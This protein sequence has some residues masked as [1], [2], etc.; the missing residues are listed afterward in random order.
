MPVLAIAISGI[1]VLCGL[2]LQELAVSPSVLGGV[3]IASA[4]LGYSLS[5]WQVSYAMVLGGTCLLVA[6]LLWLDPVSRLWVNGAWWMWVWG[7]VGFVLKETPPKRS[8][9]FPHGGIGIRGEAIASYGLCASGL[10][11]L[12]GLEGAD[13]A[14]TVRLILAI[15]LFVGGIVS[16]S[17]WYCWKHDPEKK[18]SLHLEGIW[19]MEADYEIDLKGFS[20][21]D[22]V[23][24]VEVEDIHWLQLEG[25][26]REL[27]LPLTLT[28]N[29]EMEQNFI[30]ISGLAKSARSQ[31]SL[32]LANILLPQGASILAGLVLLLLGTAL[33]WSS[34]IALPDQYALPVLCSVGLVSPALGR[35]LLHLVAPVHLHPLKPPRWIL[36]C[37]E[38]GALVW[39]GLMRLVYPQDLESFVGMSL[40]GYV[41]GTAICVL[42]LV[43]RTPILTQT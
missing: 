13:F 14:Q 8:D 20:R 28:G 30:A 7:C 36:R 41:L 35:V 9:P 3:A 12:S 5:R 19:G 24:I 29:A 18:F 39:L 11:L 34:P 22:Q 16:Y 2:A 40:G 10:F 17:G 21:I 27:T 15:S 26:N 37:W 32:A 42:A 31:D 1:A 25:Y 23:K 38:V 43:R 4:A 6:V 33:L